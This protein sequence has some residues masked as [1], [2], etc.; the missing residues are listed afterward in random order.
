MSSTH[1]SDKE[2]LASFLEE[3]NDFRSASAIA[4]W[5]KEEFVQAYAKYFK[6]GEAEARMVYLTA[7]QVSERT[8][9]IWANIKDTVASPYMKDTLFNNI[10]NSFIQKQEALPSFQKLFG[11]ITLNDCDP[12]K[13]IFGPA[14]YFVDLMRFIEEQITPQQIDAQLRLENRQPSLFH[15]DL[16]CDNTYTLLPFIDIVNEVLEAVVRDP[17]MPDAYE[18]AAQA[19]YPMDLPFNLPHS[20]VR[21]YLQAMGTHLHE[22]YETFNLVTN[23]KPG[24]NPEAGP[25]S[26]EGQIGRE[27]LNLS[28][29]E[30]TLISK[31][32]TNQKEL[33]GYFGTTVSEGLAKLSDVETFLERTGLTRTQLTELIYQDLSAQEFNA[34]LSRAFFINNAGDN[35]PP[36][37]VEIDHSDPDNLVEKLHNLSFPRLDAIYRFLLLARKLGWSFADLE[38]ALRSTQPD[39]DV[40]RV[41]KFDGINDYVSCSVKR[42]LAK[43]TVGDQITI[44]GWVQPEGDGNQIILCSGNAANNQALLVV[45]IDYA[46]RICLL[47]PENSKSQTKEE[48]ILISGYHSIPRGEFTHIAV[49]LDRS[50]REVSFYINGKL[51]TTKKPIAAYHFPTDGK[52]FDTDISLGRNF[53]DHYFEG[54]IKEV[55]IWKGIRTPQEISANRYTRF[56]GT[57]PGLVNLLGYW[58]LSPTNWNNLPDLS[59]NRNDGIPGGS[60]FI[61]QPRWVERDLV[62]DPLPA[63]PSPG[64]PPT[65]E[66]LDNPDW[67]F[68][69]ENRLAL[70]DFE[71][72]D[73]VRN[74]PRLHREFAP[75]STRT[76]QVWFKAKDKNL[77]HQKQVIY[78]EGETEGGLIMYLHDGYLY[79]GAFSDSNPNDPTWEKTFLRT[80]QITSGQWHHAAIVLDTTG[81]IPGEAFRA[82]VD[83]RLVDSG[84]AFRLDRYNGKVE[85]GGVSNGARF[86]DGKYFA[87]EMPEEESHTFQGMILEF[88]LWRDAM[89]G[90][91]IRK[92]RF[93]KSLTGAEDGL[94]I[95][96]A[97]WSG[98]SPSKTVKIKSTVEEPVQ[99][100]R[101]TLE[102]LSGIERLR[103]KYKLSIDQLCALWYAL[104]HTGRADGEVL[105]DTVFN[106]LKKDYEYWNYYADKPVVWDRTGE[107]NPKKDRVTQSRLRSSL[108]LSQKDLDILLGG[109][110]GAQKTVSLTNDMLNRMYRLS[111]FAKA[112]KLKMDDFMALLDIMQM[113]DVREIGDFIRISKRADWLKRTGLQVYELDFIIFDTPHEK[114][115]VIWSEADLRGLADDLLKQAGNILAAEDS[116]VMEG[117]DV[118]QSRELFEALAREAFL[119][120]HEV[121]RGDVSLKLYTVEDRVLDEAGLSAA[122]DTLTWLKDENG[123]PRQDLRTQI[124]EI[125]I[126]KN[127]EHFNACIAGLAGLFDSEPELITVLFDYFEKDAS[128]ADFLVW[129]AEMEEYDPVAEEIVEYLDGYEK[130]L[131][132]AD[133][134][135]L[136]PREVAFMLDNPEWFGVKDL[137]SPDIHEVDNLFHFKAL[138]TNFKDREDRLVGILATPADEEPEE[139]VA[140]LME[141][142]A[143]LAGWELPRLERLVSVLGFEDSYNTIEHLH[144]L[145]QCF[146]LAEKLQS[147]VDFLI[148][149][150]DTHNLDYA[151]YRNHADALLNI[152]HAQYEDNEAW[153]KVYRPVRNKLAEQKRN[154]LTSLAML[155]IPKDFDGRRSPDLLTEF[156]LIDVQMGSETDTSRI[157]QATLSAQLYV[158]RCLMNLEANIFPEIIPS[159]QWGWM[160]NYRVW[161]ANRKV[162]LYPENYI[163]PE[164]RD[165]KSPLFQALEDELMQGE[166]NSVNVTKALSNYLNSFI[167]LSNLE[168]VGSYRHAPTAAEDTFYLV[169]RTK[170]EPH[171]Y[172]YRKKVN[173]QKWFPWQKINLS[174]N[175]DF[176]TPVFAFGRLYLFWAEIVENTESRETDKKDKNGN[177]I[178][179]NITVLTPTIKYSYLDITNAWVPA[180]TYE[181]LNDISKFEAQLLIW[182]RIYLQQSL[183]F[184]TEI[185]QT[186]PV[187]PEKVSALLMGDDAF[188]PLHQPVSLII[189]PQNSEKTLDS[190]SVSFWLCWNKPPKSTARQEAEI[191]VA[192][193]EAK[194]ATLTGEVAT[195]QS[196]ATAANNTLSNLQAQLSTK[197]AEKLAKQNEYD[198]ETDKDKKAAI[199]AEIDTLTGIITNL[200]GQVA[201]AQINATNANQ[202]LV[203]KTAE[204]NS[205]KSEETTARQNLQTLITRETNA[206]K[207]Q[208]I[209]QY[210]NGE[211]QLRSPEDLVLHFKGTEVSTGIALTDGAWNHFHLNIKYQTNKYSVEILRD[212]TRLKSVNVNSSTQLTPN[213]QIAIGSDSQ[214]ENNPTWFD[215]LM[216]EFVVWPEEKTTAWVQGQMNVRVSLEQRESLYA[217]ASLSG[218]DK[219]GPEQYDEIDGTVLPLADAPL[220]QTEIAK[221]ERI[222]LFYGDQVRSLRN[223]LK[224]TS[225]EL[226]TIAPAL[227]NYDLN[228]Y[229]NKLYLDAKPLAG[230]FGYWK[231]LKQ[232]SLDL[233]KKVA[234][235]MNQYDWNWPN[236]APGYGYA[237]VLGDADN[238]ILHLGTFEEFV[239]WTLH[240]GPFELSLGADVHA[241]LNNYRSARKTAAELSRL[242]GELSSKKGLLKK[243]KADR[244]IQQDQ[245]NIYNFFPDPHFAAEKS[246]L[247]NKINSLGSEI[248]TLET[249]IAALEAQVAAAQIAAT[250]ASKKK[251]HK[252][253]TEEELQLL[254]NMEILLSSPLYR[255]LWG[256]YNAVLSGLPETEVHI[257]EVNNQLGWYI[258]DTSEEQMLLRETGSN[259]SLDKRLSFQY[260]DNSQPSKSLEISLAVNNDLGLTNAPPTFTLERLNTLVPH[261]LSS[262]L[263][264]DGIAGLLSLGSQGLVEP[265]F[266]QFIN[267]D[268]KAFTNFDTLP[269][270]VDF[271]GAMGLYYKELFFHIPF[272][273]ANQLNSNQRFEEAQK[274]YHYIFDPTAQESDGQHLI[275]KKDRYWRYL[276]FRNQAILDFEAL[277]SNPDALNEYHNDPFDPHAIARL[278]INAYQKAVVM[279]YIDNLLDWGDSL[280]RQDSRESIN[281]ATLLYILAYNILGP[282]PKKR[283]KEKT[284]V[285]GTYATIRE[286]QDPGIPEF[287]TPET[288]RNGALPYTPNHHME[289]NF[290]IPENENF[291]GYWDRVEDR[292]FKVRH[293]LNIDGIFRTLALF[294]PPIDPMALVR[295]AA[296]G[297]DI[298]SVLSSFNIS[299]PHY[300]YS[301]MLDKARS[302]TGTLQGLGSALL[303]ALEKKDAE[304]LSLLQNTQEQAILNLTTSIKENERDAAQVNLNGIRIALQGAQD[305]KKRYE[306]LISDGLSALE[307]TQLVMVGVAQVL[308]LGATI[309]TA[310]GAA[311]A[312]VPNFTAGGAGAFGSPVATVTTGGGSIAS[313]AEKWAKVMEIGA[314]IA[315]TVGSITGTMATYE[316]RE[317]DWKF[318]R[319]KAEK[320]IQN[321]ET[322]IE[323]ATFS[324]QNAEQE[325]LIHK[326]NIEHNRQVEDFMKSKFSN[327]DLYNWMITRISG[328]YF[329]T[330][331][332]AYDMAKLAEKALQYEFGVEDTFINFGHWDSLKK[333]L[334]AG[335]SLELDLNRMEKAAIDMDSRFLEIEKVISLRQLSPTALHELK[336]T[337][338]CT[339]KFKEE[340]FDYDY[341]GHYF[342]VIKALSITIPAVVGPYQTIKATLTQLNSQTLLSP[343]EGALP[344]LLG[345]STDSTPSIRTNWRAYQSIAISKGVNDS[346]LFELNFND[347][348][349]LPFEGTG[350][351]SEWEL[352]MPKAT[353][354]IDFDSLTDVIINL[355]YTAAQDRGLKK[356]V[357]ELLENY[358]GSTVFSLVQENPATWHQ[359][360]QSESPHKLSFTLSPQ[361]FPHNLQEVKINKV[362]L[363]ADGEALD[364]GQFNLMIGEEEI[365]LNEGDMVLESQDDLAQDSRQML[366]ILSDDKLDGLENLILMVDYSG[367]IPW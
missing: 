183:E 125:L 286:E 85:L 58:P 64:T 271:E 300:R 45:M 146:D 134:F 349:Y 33:L 223:N 48:N 331:K 81:A 175:S 225:F 310:V 230:L 259:P 292:L 305:V 184:D 132:I 130:V 22:V 346:G 214:F 17:L 328:L 14:A 307:I 12:C 135:A 126:R 10:P 235:N 354:H 268:A 221:R 37:S 109:I 362:Y 107:L 15:I 366:S 50:L 213:L 224:E 139:G 192:N 253:W 332:I 26:R 89:D 122:F 131:F 359:F 222:L 312:A 157:V 276:P 365:E 121:A 325:I 76:A 98:V 337:G 228:I 203:A 274:W 348:R 35:L 69:N 153:D 273:I 173:D 324:L 190:F 262:R 60:E 266:G 46:G 28:P 326:R 24:N 261:E 34:G 333:G 237:Y 247:S 278:R 88:Q 285:T 42:G 295:A 340:L 309:T 95:W 267:P 20:Q 62:L 112:L 277:L 345:I 39:R 356:A 178:T 323:A 155:K 56:S 367:K 44:E 288:T 116:F 218:K 102:K 244:S 101:R 193:A 358:S 172:Y 124:T 343:D 55:R 156:L 119:A 136:H 258:L 211:M 145:Y 79:F 226:K 242:Q 38:W 208:V 250:N 272:F 210:G 205:A 180:Q 152:F 298:G 314:D 202:T 113:E 83:G 360:L 118:G 57:E 315:N 140:S 204:L 7:V 164:L 18:K 217:Y 53:N 282:R 189:L 215:G 177:F 23:P 99:L 151:F 240:K 317:D 137:T 29:L 357:E 186:G 63:G 297:R 123:K 275:N 74:D 36:V 255:N 19:T 41:L 96:S 117:I 100:N 361:A 243:K 92:K 105:F 216:T 148:A 335:E 254:D 128:P 234:T 73:I 65:A 159:T 238:N 115:K 13:S 195:A 111:Q 294:Q 90:E 163:E 104:K 160:K 270:S 142:L 260:E 316:R 188:F 363:L 236:G 9:L 158:Q 75:L 59:K 66:V 227:V 143:D 25:L 106:P 199:K 191:A 212:G 299:V 97:N 231:A 287:L 353:N 304:E 347:D 93:S 302:I 149:L 265:D 168:I 201:T 154:A 141:E 138:T 219:K 263:F 280:F 94:L 200:N 351:I 169:S 78:Q 209:F 355:K 162:F 2:I 6:G 241:I 182:K 71:T 174:I 291:V 229:G 245:L 170:T 296:G 171:L 350:A 27:I 308:K 110:I 239:N 179:Q 176:V 196:N 11:A 84:K 334:L 320:E 339:F 52:M 289:Y 133:K 103:A 281:E 306:D 293:S 77:S 129:M 327:K 284:V 165:T 232:E 32:H 283:I 43:A 185:T 344:Y 144:V 233:A 40:E 30:Y 269:K 303:D 31:V 336:S 67:T 220:T 301:Y 264:T 127:E 330:Y 352:S 8:A 1:P 49:T 147:D 61:T 321:L 319:D 329:Q 166:I 70:I 161:E 167:E 150:A 197:E 252:D 342:R 82:Y 87:S 187:V 120:S 91:D 86:H 21:E 68:W 322:Q 4:R 279:K 341:P 318:E 311:G 54:I 181:R 198:Q 313:S 16:D 5:D 246:G 248:N 364:I 194:V 51:D 257:S 114:I 72:R 206:L 256:S 249:Q 80:P 47:S 207:S 251:I 3:N 108:R 338:K 290:C